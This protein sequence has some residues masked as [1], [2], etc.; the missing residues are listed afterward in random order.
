[1]KKKKS[2][3]IEIKNTPKKKKK[4]REYN[5]CTVKFCWGGQGYMSD[6]LLKRSIKIRIKTFYGNATVFEV[7]VDITSTI[8]ALKEFI[9]K[10]VKEH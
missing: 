4:K 3:L 7:E 8:N 6:K 9:K 5:V 1:M 10:N 2:V